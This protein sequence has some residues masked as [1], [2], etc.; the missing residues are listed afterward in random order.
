MKTPIQ[1]F[2]FGLVAS[3]LFA[4]AAWADHGD[5]ANDGGPI[6]K[7]EL[8]QNGY[9]FP[10][11]L[12]ANASHTQKANYAWRLFLAANQLTAA[13]L[14]SGAGR[15]DAV[16]TANFIDTGR[17]YKPKTNPLV[18]ESFYHRTEAF[19]YY[20]TASDK[21]HSPI[22]QV[23]TY[24]T[25]YKNESTGSKVAYTVSGQNYVNL[26]ETNEISQNFLYYQNSNNPNFPVLFMA[27]VNELETRYVWDKSAP[28]SSSSFDFPDTVMEVKSA[29]RRVRDIK[30]SNPN[31]YHQAQA[32]YYTAG[33]DG[34]PH[35]VSETFALIALHIIQKTANYPEFIFTTFEHIDAVTRNQQNYITDPA[36]RTTYSYLSY[37]SGD[38]SPQAS[39][40]GAYYIN[41]AGQ[42][43]KSNQLATYNLPRAGQISQSDTTVV[44]PKTISKEV[45]DVNNS[46]NAMVKSLDAGNI[47]ANY[48]LKGVQAGPTSNQTTLDYYLANIAV[49]SSQPGVQLFRG[50]LVNGGV[51][52][53]YCAVNNAITSTMCSSSAKQGDSCSASGGSGTCQPLLTN[54]R[55]DLNL[56]VGIKEGQPVPAPTY[57]MGGC[58]GCHAAASASGRDFSF[59]A[60]GVAGKGK[61]VDTVPSSALSDAAQAAHNQRMG[62]NNAGK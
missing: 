18:W 61:E 39:A 30:N 40:N 54:N 19:P 25:Y 62:T 6:T 9:Q 15:A 26:D 50:T 36:Y 7:A 41:E 29:W 34:V 1:S 56:S 16:S 51:P 33:E 10:T 60:N 22:G 2:T 20:A 31:L 23:P 24:Y 43:A 55:D 28:S 27:K 35:A 53:L 42:A 37:G 5:H 8:Q 57:N 38:S 4:T 12:V 46:V 58:Q 32:T 11:D 59:L 13:S 49:E 47:W 21:P 3:S 17:S 52:Q 45:N 44:Q 48:R 14:Q